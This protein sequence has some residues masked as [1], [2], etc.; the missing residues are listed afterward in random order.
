MCCGLCTQVGKNF[1]YSKQ[2]EEKISLSRG[3]MLLVQRDDLQIIRESRHQAHGHVRFYNPRRNERSSDTPADLLI[4]W[5]KKGL[6]MHLL[7]GWGH[8]RS[9][10]GGGEEW[11]TYLS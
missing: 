4:G 3:E 6:M 7:V 2:G 10:W 9:T 11:A 8:I 1:P 5:G